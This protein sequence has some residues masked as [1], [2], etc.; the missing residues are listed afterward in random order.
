M[1]AHRKTGVVLRPV[2]MEDL[3]PVVGLLQACSLDLVGIKEDH[4]D[5][6]RTWWTTPGLCLE[7]DTR[8]AVSGDEG[9]VGYAEVSDFATPHV[10]VEA[11]GRVH[12]GHR[13]CGIGSR[14]I[15]WED[16][17]AL[18]A[19]G[20]APED[21]RVSIS[22][23]LEV[24]DRRGH[25][26][27]ISRGYG[28]VRHF[29]RMEIALDRESEP[30]EW[31]EG[32]TVRG[33]NPVEDPLPL[34]VAADEAFRDHWGHVETPL[35]ESVE[36]TRHRMTNPAF[37]PSVWFLATERD[38]IVGMSL[39]QL[40]SAE[41][42][43]LAWINTLGVRAAWR[44]RG[45]AHALL[46]HSFRELY[47]RGKRRVCLGVDSASLTGATRVYERAGMKPTRTWIIYEK[48]IRPGVEL[49][50]QSSEASKG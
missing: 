25:E 46:R 7:T 1:D 30:I 10:R 14:L 15:E 16:A 13:G 21:A 49:S 33:F 47:R 22:Q 5:D 45:I 6:L 43:D 27:V 24:V 3:E 39:C 34:T 2:T 11:W 42:P 12:P 50:T 37:D 17:R 29:R 38:E 9:I 19:L 44:R 32:I 28:V 8:V 36:R 41:D 48:E 4:A 18:E 35:A 40:R 26:L 23:W 20:K 31:P